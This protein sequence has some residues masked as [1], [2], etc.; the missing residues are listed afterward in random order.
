MTMA[1]ELFPMPAHM[2]ALLKTRRRLESSGAEFEELGRTFFEVEFAL[3]VG[4]DVASR[5]RGAYLQLTRALEIVQQALEGE[6]D[7]DELAWLNRQAIN[8]LASA[9]LELQAVVDGAM[10][11]NFWHAQRRAE[12]FRTHGPVSQ[13]A[14]RPVARHRASEIHS[15]PTDDP[16]R[17][18]LNALPPPPRTSRKSRASIARPASARPPRPPRPP[19]P[20]SRCTS[21]PPAPRPGSAAGR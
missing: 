12:I 13:S 6:W 18:S 3:A 14:T 19:S 4:E 1:D 20:S 8:C 21:P 11:A 9:K 15:A 7:A 16:P 5:S 10:P 2:M 17:R